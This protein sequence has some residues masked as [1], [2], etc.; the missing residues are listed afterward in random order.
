M[1]RVPP[2]PPARIV[3]RRY[4]NELAHDENDSVKHL[5][6]RGFESF[7][8]PRVAIA[9]ERT[10]SLSRSTLYAAEIT[11]STFHIISCGVVCA[12]LTGAILHNPQANLRHFSRRPTA[13]VSGGQGA[14]VDKSLEAEKT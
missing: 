5:R 13:R 1:R 12:L 10:T 14:G 2:S 8:K 3:G 9:D 4:C 7:E 11:R 6:Q